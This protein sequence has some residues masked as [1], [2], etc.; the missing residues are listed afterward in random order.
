MFY[1]A[2]TESDPGEIVSA[3]R[4]LA[5]VCGT[6]HCGFWNHYIL[7]LTLQSIVYSTVHMGES[8]STRFVPISFFF[9]SSFFF[10]LQDDG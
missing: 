9:F 8:A 5:T 2:F 1:R 4:R 3:T 10:F 7:D 6:E